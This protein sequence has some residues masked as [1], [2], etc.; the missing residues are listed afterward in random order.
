M[1]SCLS[2]RG[3]SIIDLPE[4][5]EAQDGVFQDVPLDPTPPLG[6]TPGGNDTLGNDGALFED[7]VAPTGVGQLS[8]IPETTG[9]QPSPLK[10]A[11]GNMCQF[12]SPTRCGEAKDDQDELSEKSSKSDSS[13]R[14]NASSGSNQSDRSTG[15]M[16]S[17]GKSNRRNRT[18]GKQKD[19][20]DKNRRRRHYS[21]IIR[22]DMSDF[23]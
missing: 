16:G 23:R 11:F 3:W 1:S 22:E 19:K 8:T 4:L 13:H 21:S 20:K 10:N 12:L 18:R 9:K 5:E 15:A 2:S 7:T 6:E 14:T 17:K